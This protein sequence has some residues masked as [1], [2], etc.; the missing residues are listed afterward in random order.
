MKLYPA[1]LVA[2]SLINPTRG[3]VNWG[4]KTPLPWHLSDPK[5]NGH[6]LNV[7]GLWKRGINGTGVTVA[8]IDRGVNYTLWDIKDNYFKEGSYDFYHRRS[9][10]M[11]F[12]D[13]TTHGTHIAGLIAANRTS[14][15]RAG[16]AYGAK[17]S[18]ILVTTGFTFRNRGKEFTYKNQQNHIYSMSYGMG[19]VIDPIS[20]LSENVNRVFEEGVNLGR[21]GLG[22]IY[23]KSAGNGRH[24]QDNCAFEGACNSIYTIN[25]GSINYKDKAS[26]FS[27]ACTS[28]MVSAYGSSLV[29][30]RKHINFQY[31]FSKEENKCEFISGTS[32]AAPLVSGTIALVLQVRPDL[33]WRDIQHLIVQTA[34]PVD[35]THESWQTTYSGRKYSPQYGFGKINAGLIVERAKSFTKVNQQTFFETRNITIDKVIPEDTNG[36]LVSRNITSLNLK[37]SGLKKV[38][39]VQVTVTIEHARRSD[40]EIYITSPQ[41][42]TSKLVSSRPTD[43]SKLGFQSYQLMTVANWDEPPTGRW[44]LKINDISKTGQGKL[45]SWKLTLFG[46]K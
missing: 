37:S 33:T 26:S 14:K 44:F 16:I 27:E 34:V 29:R 35:L 31:S 30:F 17:F 6:D 2:T 41:N 13:T 1:Y 12:N 7:T 28:V 42:I 9:D 24:K 22:S 3:E 32:Y 46:S 4:R 11:A 38:E 8:I 36:L 5:R 39:H 40:I 19:Y 23:V 10:G 43:R 21:G 25:V 20:P 45:K 15:C 18:S